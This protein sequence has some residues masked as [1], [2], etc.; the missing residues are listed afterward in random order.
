MNGDRPLPT[1]TPLPLPLGPPGW[2]N[3]VVFN[4]KAGSLAGSTGSFLELR[5]ISTGVSIGPAKGVK[6]G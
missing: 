1:F 2:A 4:R 6:V 5:I 3:G